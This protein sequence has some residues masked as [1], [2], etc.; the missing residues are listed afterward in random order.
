MNHGPQWLIWTG[1]MLLAAP[2]PGQIAFT[3]GAMVEVTAPISFET[4]AS[5]S[6]S[7]IAI[8]DEGEHTLLED[9]FVNAF[10]PG[11]HGGTAP[12]LLPIAAGTLVRSYLVHFDPLGGSFGSLAGE[13][14]FVPGEFIIG[15]QTHTPLLYATD[16]VLGDPMATYPAVFDDFRGFET[17]PGPDGVTLPIDMTSASFSLFAE[18]GVDHARIITRPVPGPTGLVTMLGV[19][20]WHTLRRRRR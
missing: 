2:A 3:T 18:L 5:E 20:A 16:P 7:V 8:L 11:T 12:P 13:V 9:V 15:V 14:F 19:G 6:S 4:G 17:L 10:G 1:A